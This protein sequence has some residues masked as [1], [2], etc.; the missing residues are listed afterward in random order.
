VEEKLPASF[1]EVVNLLGRFVGDR[2]TL[3]EIVRGNERQNL[4]L[5]CLC[6][7]RAG[8]RDDVPAPE[9]IERLGA[10]R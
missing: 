2:Q 1:C 6:R 4:Y 10:G 7:Y 3:D 9:E 8:L 5:W